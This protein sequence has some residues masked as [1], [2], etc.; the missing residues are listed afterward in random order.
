MIKVFIAFIVGF[1]LAGV[2]LMFNTKIHIG[3]NNKIL[4]T[5]ERLPDVFFE[6][7]ELG[8]PNSEGCYPIDQV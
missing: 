1:L 6:H 8:A 2:L 7:Y 4:T 5:I 3:T